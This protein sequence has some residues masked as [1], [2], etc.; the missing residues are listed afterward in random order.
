MNQL[1]PVKTLTSLEIAQITGK[2]HDHVMRD[3]R[4]MVSALQQAQS[5]AP[6]LGWFC[7][8][9]IYSDAKGEERKM[10]LL[11]KETSITL[12]A[13]YDVVARH[14]IVQRWQQL[15][16]QYTP[17]AVAEAQQLLVFTQRPK[18]IANSKEVNRFNC[19]QGG[20]KQI[21]DYNR[22]NCFYHTGKLPHEITE[23]AKK[24]QWPAKKRTSAKEVIRQVRPAVGSSMALADDFCKTGKVAIEEAATFCK[25]HALP[26][27][28]KMAEFGL[29]APA[30]PKLT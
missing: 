22:K 12:L 20:P 18:Q 24:K 7:Q 19:Q 10:F 4:K 25:T 26:L 6:T 21:V 28:E 2:R 15:E 17:V 9:G 23:W 14:K 3:I 11:D 16:A 13:G 30:S 1:Q 27:F 8:S 29:I 5:T